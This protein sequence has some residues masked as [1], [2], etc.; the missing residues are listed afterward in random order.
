MPHQYKLPLRVPYEG[1]IF[2]VKPHLVFREDQ[3]QIYRSRWKSKFTNQAACISAPTIP[4][5]KE[6]LS[7]H[8]DGYRFS[9]G[10]SFKEK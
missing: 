1:K 4:K 8:W 9:G 3:W 6:I 2:V 5:L 10:H 7:K